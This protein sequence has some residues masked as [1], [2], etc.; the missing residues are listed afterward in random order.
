MRY[1][2]LRFCSEPTMYQSLVLLLCFKKKKKKSSLYL[3][4][5]NRVA[6]IPVNF[7][8]HRVECASGQAHI[9]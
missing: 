8:K 5:V 1:L 7:T 9:E 3:L 6:V 4:H 2:I